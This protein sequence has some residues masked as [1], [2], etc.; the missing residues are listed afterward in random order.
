MHNRQS[1]IGNSHNTILFSNNDNTKYVHANADNMKCIVW[2]RY[3][4]HFNK[5]FSNNFAFIY[6]INLFIIVCLAFCF[7]E[8]SLSN[9]IQ[10]MTKVCHLMRIIN[11]VIETVMIVVKYAIL[12]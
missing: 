3:Y 8:K 6:S 2:A 4:K 11:Y 7:S 1:K 9:K 5:I 10:I 12:K